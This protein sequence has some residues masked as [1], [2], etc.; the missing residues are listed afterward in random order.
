MGKRKKKKNLVK[1]ICLAILVTIIA[2]I[3]IGTGVSN[4]NEAINAIA[5][6]ASTI[7]NSIVDTWDDKE[8]NVNTNVIHAV[9]GTLE[10]HTIDVGQGDSTL[11]L[12]GNNAMLIDCGTKSK[13]QD[14]TNYLQSLGISKIDV[15]IGT[16]P[17][18][19]HM[20]GMAE[21]IKNFEIGV[22]YT[23]DNTNDN[24]TTSWY[25]EFLDAVDEKDIEWKY[26]KVRRGV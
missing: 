9:D 22:L 5:D 18:D 8:G 26:P 10:M 16:H 14:V 1:H 6:T 4:V 7:T 13:G 12:Q 19:D 21:V 11:I 2:L 17:H 25:M 15:L 3:C 24:I 23:P 20:G